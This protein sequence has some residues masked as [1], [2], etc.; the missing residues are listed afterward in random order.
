MLC[1][2]LLVKQIAVHLQMK[3][4]LG[5]KGNEFQ[6]QLYG[7]QWHWVGSGKGWF[8]KVMYW[9][10]IRIH[11]P[12]WQSLTDGE[13]WVTLRGWQVVGREAL[14]VHNKSWGE[15]GSIF[16]IVVV[17]G[18]HLC[19]QRTWSHTLSASVSSRVLVSQCNSK[20]CNCPGKLG[21]RSPG[22]LC[23]IFVTSY[24]STGLQNTQ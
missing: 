9:V 5:R 7:S 15:T 6:Q 17:P 19:G 2:S 4:C 16:M 22:T 18:R 11:L 12:K 1:V 20:G 24:D 14:S 3:L 13:Q 10:I 21:E 23:I 8:P